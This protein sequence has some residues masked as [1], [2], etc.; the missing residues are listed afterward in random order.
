MITG[1]LIL[2]S[3]QFVEGNVVFAHK[4]DTKTRAAGTVVVSES[5]DRRNCI[6]TEKREVVRRCVPLFAHVCH[7]FL[8][9]VPVRKLHNLEH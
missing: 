4:K 2:V 9:E 6:V 1:P 3:S 8:Q 5:K 7:L